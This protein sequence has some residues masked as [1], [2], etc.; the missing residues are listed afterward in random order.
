MTRRQPWLVELQ[1]RVFIEMSREL[2]ENKDIKNG[3]LCLVQSAR[4]NLE[5]VAVVTDRLQ[6]LII[7][8]QKVYQV[9]LPWHFGWMAPKDGGDTA[10]ILTPSIGDANTMIPE[11]KAFLVNVIKKNR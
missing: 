11:T 4:G 9:G 2:A 8:R 3:D 7:N 1:P 5:A 6:P 10:N